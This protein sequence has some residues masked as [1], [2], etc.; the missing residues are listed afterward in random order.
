VMD[1]RAYCK[2]SDAS[3]NS[4]REERMRLNINALAKIAI[5][6]DSLHAVVS[7]QKGRR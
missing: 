6:T 7:G 1:V 5:M 2:A 4:R 3:P